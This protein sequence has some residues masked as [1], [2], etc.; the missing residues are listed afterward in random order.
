V[1][2][3]HLRDTGIEA[4]ASAEDKTAAIYT[5]YIYAPNVALRHGDRRLYKIVPRNRGPDRQSQLTGP[6][7]GQANRQYPESDVRPQQPID[8]FSQSA[9]Y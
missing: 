4:N 6:N 5:P 3:D 7:I 2:L 8:D 9:V 1:W